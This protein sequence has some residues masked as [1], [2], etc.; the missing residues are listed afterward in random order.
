MKTL[1]VAGSGCCTVMLRVA[2]AV[3]PAPSC[4][5][6]VSVCGPSATVVVFQLN[7]AVVLV[8]DV[9]KIGVTPPSSRSVHVI[10]PVPLLSLM[11]TGMDPLSVAPSAGLVIDAVSDG[12]AVIVKGWAF[13]TWRSGLRTVTDAE[14]AVAMS[15]AAIVAVSWVALANVVVRAAPFHCRVLPAT[16]LLPLAVSVKAAPPA[17]AVVGD[18]DVSTGA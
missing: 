9:V 8:P 7:D 4:T 16:K 17:V 2:V 13:E 3:R 15:A 14:P 6:S 10:V 1:I 12:A 18:T 11:P 5:V